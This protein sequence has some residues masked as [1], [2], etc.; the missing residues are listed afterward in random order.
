MRNRAAIRR[1]ILKQAACLRPGG[2]RRLAWTVLVL[3]FVL[4]IGWLNTAESARRKPGSA[5]DKRAAAPDKRTDAGNW[6][7]RW[8]KDVT[9]DNVLPEYPRPAMVRK[10]WINL[11]GLW[12]Y[13]ITGRL[14]FP[15]NL[16]N[17]E[18]DP[19]LKSTPASPSKWDGKILV[20]FVPEALLSKVSRFVWPSQLLWYRKTFDTPADW[21]GQHIL[22]HFEAVDWHCVVWVNGR[23]VGEHKGGYV[24]F[25][26]DVTEALRP[27]GPQEILVVVWDPTSAGD[28]SS[29]KQHLPADS[30]PL[31]YPPS[32]GIWQT[33]WLEPVPSVSI[34]R[35]VLTPDLDRKTLTAHVD[36][37]GQAPGCEVELRAMDGDRLAATAKGDPSKELSLSIPEPKLWSPDSPFLYDL[38]VILRRDGRELDEVASYFGMRK[39]EVQRDAAGLPRIMLNGKRIF[40]FGPLD[41]GI[42][43]D[44]VLTP[45]SDAAGRFEVQY[46]KDIGCNMARFHM[47][48]HPER[49]YYWCDKLGLIVWQDFV[50]MRASNTATDSPAA[51]QWETEQRELMDHLR[52]H[53]SLFTW[54]VFNESWGQYDTER[55][56][57]W[58]MRYDPSR[59]VCNATGWN[60]CR[61]GHTFDMHDYS[62]HPSVAAPGQTGDR[63][64]S[65]GECG[66]FNV[67]VPGH[68]IGDRPPLQKFDPAGDDFRATIKDGPSW[69]KPY[70]DWIE[71][72]WLLQSQG[73]CAAVYTQ[74]YDSGL[75]CNGWLTYDRAVSKIPIDTLKRMHSRLYRPLPELRTILPLLKTKTS[76]CHWW[77]GQPPKQWEQMQLDDSAWA[78]T[79]KPPSI[80]DPS[81]PGKE[82]LLCVRREF[83]LE[84]IPKKA[85][86]CAEGWADFT[87]WLNGRRIQ[88]ISNGRSESYTPASIAI[89]SPE[90]LAALRPGR[91]VMAVEIR[92]S[93]GRMQKHGKLDK[94][95]RADF[96]LVEVLT[97]DDKK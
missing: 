34:E 10:K 9:P 21:Q 53:P 20:P 56:T 14:E 70:A 90:A 67:Y 28:Q 55:I 18:A 3:S 26:C 91:N 71:G 85:A 39:V 50:C 32:T 22:L 36:L 62:F 7:S 42:W 8:T 64:M 76:S 73:L 61:V 75:E 95:D 2:R 72:L 59:L 29:G 40:L 81:S 6:P 96:G 92:P 12:D 52:I 65:I 47:I 66:G 58:V 97:G 54:I 83:T 86:L 77:R 24:P 16:P 82:S 46:L 94:N 80:V 38:K 25:A 30:R 45:P 11:N 88:T 27:Q 68:M 5:S 23:K 78:V 44:G 4:M 33:V 35:L 48:V 13:A 84:A 49:C 87:V 69:E 41:Q 15:K 51:R 19:L 31:V 63:A 89:L 57:R 37:R 17:A 74:I 43:P 79:P 1:G 93:T 60:D